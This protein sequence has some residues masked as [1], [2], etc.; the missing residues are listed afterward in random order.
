MKANADLCGAMMRL[1]LLINSS[2]TRRDLGREIDIE[3]CMC[4]IALAAR[5]TKTKRRSTM[6]QKQNEFTREAVYS[7][8]QHHVDAAMNQRPRSKARRNN[9][10]QALRCVKQL[11]R[12][13]R[14]GNNDGKA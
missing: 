13:E 3:L 2:G 5:K 8:L 12:I 14:S 6:S 7:R 1:R 4:L 9:I 11:K 10:A